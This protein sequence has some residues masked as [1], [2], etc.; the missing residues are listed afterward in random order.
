[1]SEPFTKQELAEVKDGNISTLA[2]LDRRGFI[3]GPEESPAD[4]A[5]RLKIFQKNLTNVEK[6]LKEKKSLTIEDM[7][8]PAEERIPPDSFNPAGKITESLYDFKINWVP[9]FFVTPS[10][11][12][13]FGGCAITSNRVHKD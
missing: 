4:F 11:G 9:G 10:F 12:L 13:L 1:M 5:A 6:E 3:M 8:F 2:D 7:T